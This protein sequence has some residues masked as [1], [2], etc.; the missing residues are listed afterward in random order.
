MT[1]RPLTASW[2]DEPVPNG[3]APDRPGFSLPVGT[4][5]FLLTDVEGSTRRWETAREPMAAAIARHYELLDGAIA[6]HNGVRPVEQGEGDSVVGAFSRASDAVAAA[7]DAQRRLR[8]E[9]WPDGVTLAVRMAVHTGEAELR[10]E[11]NYFGPAVIRCARLR[12]VAAGGQVLVSSATADLVGDRL[13]EGASLADLGRHR[14]RDLGRPEHVFELRHADVAGD[15]GPLRSLDNLPNNLPLQLTS[16]VGRRTE[17]RHLRE[18]VDGTRLL[19]VTGAGG[20][21]KTRL[22]LQLAADVLDHYPGGV[23]FVELASVNEPDRV[24]VTVAGALG[25]RDLSGDLV[26][27][28]AIRVGPQPT[29]LVLDNC[30]HLLGAVAALVDGLLRRCET[31]TIVATTREPLN[32]PG[33][34]AWRVP[35]MPV[36]APHDVATIE[37]LSQ[38]DAVQL[39]VDRATKARPNFRLTNDNGPIVAQI[40]HRLDGIPLAVELAAARVRSLTIERVA[41]GLDDR[42]R[43]LTGG[44]RTVLPR[45]QTLQ[46]SIDWSYDLLSDAERAAF[47]RLTVFAGG[48]TLDG[49][50]RIVVG[51]DIDQVDVLDLLSAL[52]DKSMIDVD[53]EHGRYRMLESLRQYAGARLIDADEMVRARAAHLSWVTTTYDPFVIIGDRI[54]AP[55]QLEPDIENL[56]VAFEWAASTGDGNVAAQLA[57]LLCCWETQRGDPRAAQVLV[58][59]ALELEGVTVRDRAMALA[60]RAWACYELGD[61]WAGTERATELLDLAEE[62]DDEARA[63]TLSIASQGFFFGAGFEPLVRMLLL[64]RQSATAANRP[65]LVTA[66]NAALALAEYVWGDHRKAEEYG[67]GV[68]GDP[69]VLWSALNVTWGREYAAIMAGRFDEARA[70]LDALGTTMSNPRLAASRQVSY[71]QLDLAQGVDT[72]AID[73]LAVM[74]DEARRRNFT[75]AVGQLGWAPGFWR[76]LRGD[77]EA[78]ALEVLAW[79]DEIDMRWGGFVTPALLCLGRVAEARAELEQQDRRSTWGAEAAAMAANWATILARLEGDL[80]GAEQLAHDAVTNV[81]GRGFRVI[82]VQSLESLAGVTAALESYTECARLAGA[83]QRLR[84]EIGLASR[85]P[86]EEALREADFRAARAA[87]GD[88]AFDAAFA[89]GATLDE[90][91]A[92]AYAQRARGERKR[93]PAGWASLTP[94]ELQVVGLVAEGLTNK[95]IAESLLMGAETVKTHLAHVYDKLGVRT[96]AGVAAEFQRRQ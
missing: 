96:R 13:P 27:A 77:V 64:A 54:D 8:A 55:D 33:E 16:F 17:L 6:A 86:F 48:F 92:V 85:W 52:V 76:M 7:L 30:E 79:R 81:H 49:A 73:R 38:F 78:G 53:E 93:P 41:A 70:L 62:L 14:L 82:L 65:D 47:R 89:E 11:G 44:A 9:D 59:R 94:T 25:E 84:D 91:A 37:S 95:Q 19:A 50:E 69:T 34:T 5:T 68:G 56:R 2:L 1:L 43:L 18:L 4:V 60:L 72:G 26:E 24:A 63:A 28:I 23:W 51:D 80:A 87:I 32:V 88:D 20:C 31:L 22:V 39:F 61:E 90:D 35:S 75:S 42:F 58:D 71:V 21:G 12:A 15:F 29:L 57:A 83:A 36:P 46:A 40:C 74:L 45:Q 66:T 10:D 3:L 67:R